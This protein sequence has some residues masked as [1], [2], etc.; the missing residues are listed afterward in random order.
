MSCSRTRL[1]TSL[2]N[3]PDDFAYPSGCTARRTATMSEKKKK[4]KRD[5]LLRCPLA[6]VGL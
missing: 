4:R 6:F 2:L 1:Y 3:A 5:R